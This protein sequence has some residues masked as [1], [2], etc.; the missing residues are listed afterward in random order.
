MERRR[1]AHPLGLCIIGVDFYRKKGKISYHL[2][3]GIEAA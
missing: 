1:M 3:S 2:G